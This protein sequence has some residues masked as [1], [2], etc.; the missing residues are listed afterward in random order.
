MKA[1]EQI[2]ETKRKLALLETTAN[3][4]TQELEIIADKLKAIEPNK[5]QII[6]KMFDRYFGNFSSWKRKK[7]NG[8]LNFF[9]RLRS[10]FGGLK[11]NTLN[12]SIGSAI[13]NAF[14]KLTEAAEKAVTAILT[15]AL[16]VA[17]I[18]L[19]AYVSFQGLL[20]L[21][22]IGGGAV[23]NTIAFAAICQVLIGVIFVGFVIYSINK[24]AN[25]LSQ[26][27]HDIDAF[28]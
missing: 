9:K 21:F 16:S 1:V 14:H 6:Q 17:G 7:I 22:I 8:V 4:E 2:A 11:E 5:D 26:G 27:K 20:K 12:E 13:A 23:T 19:G 10:I 24:I 18:S 25:Y 15:L 3:T 28:S